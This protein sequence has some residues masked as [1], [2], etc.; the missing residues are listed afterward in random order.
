MAGTGKEQPT[1]SE[2]SKSS[3]RGLTFW[4]A[5]LVEDADCALASAEA[6]AF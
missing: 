2:E 4:L 6:V 3:F 1:S 5:A